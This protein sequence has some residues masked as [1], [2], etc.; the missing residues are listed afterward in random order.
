MTTEK[1]IGNLLEDL[2]SAV[3]VQE[4][5]G[6]PSSSRDSI[7]PVVSGVKNVQTL[8]QK[9]MDSLEELQGQVSYYRRGPGSEGVTDDQK[10][11]LE[12]LGY[13]SLMLDSVLKKAKD[14]V[15]K[16]IKDAEGLKG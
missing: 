4:A 12:L 6:D 7:P 5:V 9:V 3:G 2:R 15:L 8:L 16:M 13:S 14:A 10:K 11:S 1:T